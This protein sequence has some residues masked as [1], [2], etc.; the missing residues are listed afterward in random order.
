M[1][2]K[3]FHCFKSFTVLFFSLGIKVLANLVWLLTMVAEG[4]N[5]II[6]EYWFICKYTQNIKAVLCCDSQEPSAIP[7]GIS[8]HRINGHLF[9]NITSFCNLHLLFPF[10][11]SLIYFCLWKFSYS[12]T[13]L[14]Q[15]FWRLPE[16]ERKPWR[17]W[18]SSKKDKELQFLTKNWQGN[19]NDKLFMPKYLKIKRPF[20]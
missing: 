7:F 13:V 14:P 8:T 5:L 3:S 11:S 12:S 9:H 15:N 20:L 19:Y 2:Q 10:S 17:L 6:S 4:I 1:T 18:T 16:R